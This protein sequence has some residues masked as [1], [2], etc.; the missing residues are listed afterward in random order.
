MLVNEMPEFAKLENVD[1]Y[2]PPSRIS[3]NGSNVRHDII[4]IQANKLRLSR[5]TS[6]INFLE[7]MFLL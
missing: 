7:R 4:L 2:L 1:T 3:A 6:V 5:P